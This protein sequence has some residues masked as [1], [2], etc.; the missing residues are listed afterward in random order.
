MAA[1]S[2]RFVFYN[3]SDTTLVR[4]G[5]G[6]DHGIWTRQPP[7][8]IPP[9]T[10][11]NWESESNGVLTG[12]EGHVDYDIQLATG[13][14]A[15]TCHIYWDNPYVGSNEYEEKTPETFQVKRLGGGGDNAVVRLTFSSS[16]SARDGIPDEWKKKGVTLDP[17]DG[18]GPQFIDLPAMGADVNRPDVFVQLDWMADATHSHALSAAAIKT[19]VD[20]FAASPYRSPTGSVGI[21]LHIDAGP[22]S[23]MNHATGA[24]WGALSRARQLSHV[25]N[26]GTAMVDASNN[27]TSYNW[28]A[29]DAV[30]KQSGGFISTGRA[31]IF[32][33]AISAHQLG[34]AVNSGIARTIPGSDMILTLGTFAA[35]TDLIMA[36]TLMHEIGHLLGLDH[37]GGDA[38]NRKPNYVSVMNYHWQTRGLT[39]GGVTGIVDFSNIALDRLFEGALDE[40]SGVGK[41]AAGVAIRRWVPGAAG[42]AGAYVQV[43]DGSLPIDWNNDGVATS[44]SVAF[45]VNNDVQQTALEPFDDWAHLRL[46]GGAISGA[47]TGAAYQPPMQTKSADITPDEAELML[48]ADTTP[49]VTTATVTPPPNGRGW[50]RST[51][52]VGFSATDDISGVAAT[53]AAVDGAGEFRV[54]GP[55]VVSAEGMH[56]VTFGSVDYSQNVEPKQ[57]L[58]VRIDK[59]A[60]EAVIRFDPSTD[61]VVVF[62]RDG[63]SG[64]DATAVPILSRTATS[65]TSFGSDVAELRVYQL[66]DYADNTTTLTLKVRCSPFAWEASVVGLSYDDEPHNAARVRRER[67]KAEQRQVERERAERQQ[68]RREREEWERREH[69]EHE[70]EHEEHE[71][72]EHE[73]HEEHEHEEHEH[74]EHEHEEHEHETESAA[75]PVFAMPNTMVFERLIARS[76][77]GALLGVRQAVSIDRGSARRTVRARFDVLDDLSLIQRDQGE[78]P[79]AEQAASSPTSDQRGLVL[80][81]VVTLRGGLTLE[82]T[83]QP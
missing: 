39:K 54:S 75:E 34:V 18:S 53:F 74:E 55:V 48:P 41:N 52:Q 35:L 26:F 56:A 47:G 15:G 80:V 79:C 5:G 71:E 9:L 77:P 62:T 50:H 16:S 58:P 19:V 44:P 43:A 4:I 3:D 20:A 49:P 23:I 21:N 64:S 70:H 24:T 25:A 17:G 45:D 6:L 27:A 30:K 12:T 66:S 36:G 22:N 14:S 57:T 78:T 65:W 59:T 29:F 40:R 13:G 7:L 11:A 2:T 8:T 76:R 68:E 83:V 32:R 61:D 81:Q 38:V 72:H 1:R 82:E 28:T 33:Y 42:A 60:P 69:E 31:P 67:E 37:G 63:L 10:N 46:V 73:E 51:V